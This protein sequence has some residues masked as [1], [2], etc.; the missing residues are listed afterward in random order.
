MVPDCKLLA[1]YTMV[2]AEFDLPET[3]HSLLFAVCFDSLVDLSVGI[4]AAA[5]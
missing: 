2:K 3:V 1:G 4:V 5:A